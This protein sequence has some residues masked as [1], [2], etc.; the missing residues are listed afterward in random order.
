MTLSPLQVA[1]TE[2][3]NDMFD[4]DISNQ[5]LL[6]KSLDFIIYGKDNKMVRKGQFRAPSVQ[7]RTTYMQAGD[8]LLQVMVN[9]CDYVNIPFQKS[10]SVLAAK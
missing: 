6:Y 9:E 8:Y 3:N 4:V 7:L 5:T 2:K 1:I 10:I